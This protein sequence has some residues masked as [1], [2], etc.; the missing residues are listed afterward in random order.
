MAADRFTLPFQQV[1]NATPN[2]RAGSALYFYAAGT[3]TPLAVYSDKD[4]SASLGTSVT[5]NALGQPATDVFLA[6]VSYK[7][8]LKDENS[9]E[10]W[11]A[12]SVYGPAFSTTAQFRSVTGSPNGQLAG[13][14]G[15][16]GVPANVAWDY[17][18]N[19][20]YV[21][22]SSGTASTAVWTA[23]NASTAAAVVPSPQ[24]YLTPTSDTPIIA[25][26]VTGASAI[27]YTPRSGNIVPIYNG[28]SFVPTTF[29]ELTLTLAASHAANAIYDVF[30]FSNNGVVT[31]VTGPAW[32]NSGSGTGARGSGGGTT[33][34]SK[35]QGLYV[36]AVQITGRNGSTTYTIAA[37]QATYLGSIFIDGSAGQVTCHRSWGQSRKW[38][39]W[40]AF[41]RA[42]LYLKGGDGT[43]SWTY[44][45]GTAQPANNNT[46]NKVTVFCGL[47][48]EIVAAR[49]NVRIGANNVSASV[50][51][52]WGS[53]TT[54]SG[55][56]G[57]LFPPG[58][59]SAVVGD[60]FG[61]YFAPPQL[62]IVD[63]TSLEAVN[64]GTA[65]YFG[66]QS[67]FQLS[68]MWRG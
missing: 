32:T 31:L 42:A 7:V 48:E 26:D 2:V 5:L 44:N 57:L 1:F 63:V 49:T 3:D 59:G 22:T 19:I 51:I 61:E 53:T 38:G 15:S 8:K 4:L 54:V 43:A 45:S 24:G 52:G 34:L 25:S 37:N 46:A 66:T 47:A 6:N 23:V 41:N 50:S 39:V 28:S 64:G 67:S 55:K 17:V 68:A 40:N 14:A 36:N 62:G 18:A 12:D 33:A 56:P 58:A 20:L 27:Y 21:C 10:I 16:A 35:V 60:V 13:T 9:I 29:S 11:S 30:V 65:T